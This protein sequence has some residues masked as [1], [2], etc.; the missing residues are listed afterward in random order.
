MDE[1]NNPSVHELEIEEGHEKR[2]G[3]YGNGDKK[4]QPLND[5]SQD[6]EHRFG[7]SIEDLALEHAEAENETEEFQLRTKDNR[8]KFCSSDSPNVATVVQV[9]VGRK[10]S[11]KKTVKTRTDGRRVFTPHQ[12]FLILDSWLRSKLAAGDFAPL[13]GVSK[14]TLY[15]WKKAFAENGLA[16]LEDRPPGSPR[17]SQLSEFTKRAILRLKEENPTWG[18][19]RLHD[20]LVRGQGI[21][22]SSSAIS[23]CLKSNGYVTQEVATRPHRD[24]KRRFERSRPNELWQ[25]DLF[26]FTLKRQNRRVHLVGYMDDYSRYIVGF[27][28][29]ATA[30]GSLV[31]EVLEQAIA[32]YGAPEEI[33]TDNGSQY[34]TWR[35]KSAFTKHLE[36]RGIKQVVARPRHPQTL[37]KIERFWGSLWRECLAE[38]VFQNYDDAKLRIGHFIDHYNF[39][40]PHQGIGGLAPADRFFD[41]AS[42]VKATLSERV[43]AN[44]LE[45]AQH[46]APRKRFYLTG[47]VGDE[48]ISLHAEGARVVLTRD[49]K[50]R[51]EVNLLAT[52]KRAEP[53]QTTELPEPLAADSAQAEPSEP[54]GLPEPLTTDGAPPIE[55]AI[56]DEPELSPGESP[57]DRALVVL[58]DVCDKHSIGD[59]DVSETESSNADNSEGHTDE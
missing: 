26:T 49:G 8:G 40:R 10:R 2:S 43:A 13:V 29:H 28:L 17:G 37:G 48:N 7:P 51:E 15:K 25:T 3:N 47:R 6:S 56:T 14:H 22:V 1:V 11:K 35:G 31:R 46:G 24:K 21:S 59:D 9:P 23:R 44:S 27:G 53:G 54:T 12:R 19:D 4:V 20:V 42:T 52:G 38:A 41:A 36:K 18:V 50:E 5:V 16:G 57:L 30:S 45:I 39:Q 55:A 33:L 34:V 58:R 32:N